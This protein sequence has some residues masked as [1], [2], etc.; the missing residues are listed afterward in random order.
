MTT[1]ATIE[2]PTIELPR[3]EG[4]SAR[5]HAAR[6][7]YILAGPGRSFDKLLERFQTATKP[8]PTKRRDTLV[9]WST[10]YDWQAHARRYD[11]LI[12]DMRT[13]AQTQAEIDAYRRDLEDH[14]KRYGDAGK[15][16]YVLAAGLTNA[17]AAQLRGQTIEGKDGKKYT[18]P[19]MKL[20][21]GAIT[22]LARA[23]TIAADLEAHAL[24]LGDILPKLDHDNVLDSQ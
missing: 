22:V 21:Q 2:R 8:P 7:E 17:I 3:E 9:D 12:L 23:L 6:V 4:E 16:L 19:T 10:Q 15:N 5:A 13:Q 20:D 24:R 14:R 18:I 11:D 1:P